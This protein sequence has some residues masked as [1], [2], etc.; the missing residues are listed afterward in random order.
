VNAERHFLHLI[1]LIAEAEPRR[2]R[3]A[4]GAR[5]FVQTSRPAE[6]ARGYRNK[7]HINIQTNPS[8]A[9]PRQ[10]FKAAAKPILRKNDNGWKPE[11]CGLTRKELREIVAQMLG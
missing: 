8:E 7:M 4:H 5:R 9:R 11:P 3:R 10:N 6:A 1:L 2:V